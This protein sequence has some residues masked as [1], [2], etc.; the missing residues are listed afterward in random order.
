MGC[1]S[2]PAEGAEEDG[3]FPA[4]RICSL[5]SLLLQVLDQLL[6]PGRNVRLLGMCTPVPWGGAL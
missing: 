5:Q 2:L 3:P 1:S 4:D 6:L